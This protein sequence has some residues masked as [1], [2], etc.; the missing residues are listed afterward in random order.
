M[1]RRIV[2]VAVRFLLF[3]LLLVLPILAAFLGPAFYELSFFWGMATFVPEGLVDP[4]TQRVYL[5]DSAW[6]FALTGW[7]AVAALCAYFAAGMRLVWFAF[8]TCAIIVAVTALA[9]LLLD[10]IGLPAYSSL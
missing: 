3:A 8:F 1:H 10:L 2:A 7:A 5:G 6:K 9:H 4:E